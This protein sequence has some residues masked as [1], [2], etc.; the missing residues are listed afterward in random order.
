MPLSYPPTGPTGRIARRLRRGARRPLLAAGVLSVAPATTGRSAAS[1]PSSPA[2]AAATSS[3]VGFVDP[4]GAKVPAA[5]V[6]KEI[7]D[8]SG[9]LAATPPTLT[10][11]G[12]AE[13]HRR[14]RD[15]DRP[16][17]RGRCRAGPAGRTTGR[18]GCT[19]A[20]TTS[21]R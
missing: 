17:G 2:G 9:E 12:D 7:K 1:T 5:D 16:G 6:T 14:H 20:A 18:C 4:A 11:T 8:L 21:G 19:Q 15:R 3:Q 10:A 13:D